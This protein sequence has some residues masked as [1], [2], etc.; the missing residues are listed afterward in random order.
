ME[1][2]VVA[3]RV[4]CVCL[5]RQGVAWRESEFSKFWLSVLGEVSS[6]GQDAG[7][8]VSTRAAKP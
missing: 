2:R 8:L 3:L 5:L 1:I 4:L 6:V 7:V